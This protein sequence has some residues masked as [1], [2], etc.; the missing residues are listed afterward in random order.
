MKMRI[1]SL[2]IL[3][4]ATIATP[5][6]QG[7]NLARLDPGKPTQLAQIYPSQRS[8]QQVDIDA[9]DLAKPHFL[10]ITA[11]S[12]ARLSG[13]VFL[14]GVLFKTLSSQQLQVDLAP[15]L[16]TGSNLIEVTGNYYPA[17]A[18]V[19]LKLSGPGLSLSSQTSGSGTLS[20]NFGLEVW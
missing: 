13:K 12:G 1:L 8:S 14:N 6:A 18:S 15:Y 5:A 3:S 17:S 4:T 7:V 16:K 9:A 20:Q 11:P 10:E 2:A 19:R